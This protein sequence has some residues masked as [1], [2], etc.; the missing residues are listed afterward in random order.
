MMPAESRQRMSLWPA[1]V[2]VQESTSHADASFEPLIWLLPTV[3]AIIIKLYTIEIAL[4]NC[5]NA[6]RIIYAKLSR[7]ESAGTVLGLNFVWKFS[8]LT[9]HALYVSHSVPGVSSSTSKFRRNVG[10]SL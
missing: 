6:L 3:M 7:L 9:N 4:S 2:Q 8:C 1:K 10:T 5:C